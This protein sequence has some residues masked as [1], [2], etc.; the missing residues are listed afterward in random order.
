MTAEDFF[1]TVS[2]T[3]CPKMEDNGLLKNIKY[4]TDRVVPQFYVL[5]VEELRKL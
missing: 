2:F 1:V 4:K 5:A 3:P